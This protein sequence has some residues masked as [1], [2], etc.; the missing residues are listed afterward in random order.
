M[1]KP[2]DQ[3][4][5]HPPRHAFPVFVL[6]SGDSIPRYGEAWRD[7]GFRSYCLRL[8]SFAHTRG[9]TQ[10]QA[11]KSAFNGIIRKPNKTISAAALRLTNVFHASVAD[12]NRLHAFESFCFWQDVSEGELWNLMRPLGVMVTPMA[13]DRVDRQSIAVP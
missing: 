8:G 11:H 3:A 5:R 7:T 12:R 1:P 2:I 10:H 9:C 6:P 13:S 4:G